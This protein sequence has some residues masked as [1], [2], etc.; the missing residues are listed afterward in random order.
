MGQIIGIDLGTTNSAVA[1]FDGD[2]PVLV[3][4]DRG[5]RITPSIVAFDEAGTILIGESAKNQAVVNAR[6][7]A[8]YVKR[9]LGDPQWRFEV[10]DRVYTA[11]ELSGLILK[12]LKSDAERY[13]GTTIESAV[14]TVPAHFG[15]A[16]RKATIEAGHIA[17]LRVPRILNEPTSAALA[18]AH[19][20]TGTNRI[21]V[22]DLGGGTFDVTCLLQ[23]GSE[24]TVRSTAGDSSLGGIDFDRLLLDAVAADFE[25]QSGLDLRGDP[26]MLQQLTELCERAK[27]EL[28]TQETATV[29]IPFIGAG[30]AMHLRRTIHR[31][32]LNELIAPLVRRTVKLTLQAV[33]EAG[34]GLEGIDALVLS[35]GSSRIP[36]VHS[37]LRRALGLGEVALVNPDEIVA[38]GAAVQAALL[39]NGAGATLRDVT[40]FNLGVEI[41]GG[42]FVPIVLRNAQLPTTEKRVFTTI[43]DDQHSVEIHVMQGDSDVVGENQSLGRFLLSGIRSAAKGKPRIEVSFMLDEDGLATITATDKD[44]QAHERIEVTP[45][46]HADALPEDAVERRRA[47]E[48]TALL[49]RIELLMRE[50]R[51]GVDGDLQEDIAKIVAYSRG[52]LAEARP[53]I[54][55]RNLIALRAAQG[56]LSFDM[57]E[58]GLG[59]T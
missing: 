18:Y 15:E 44:T 48:I 8:S 19:R 1:H 6:R 31:D 36:L 52:T 50:R 37:Y 40:A 17:G 10:D 9:H 56:E 2:E 22:Y 28:S 34:F 59:K 51:A 12:K 3:P 24:F 23:E 38:A 26:V 11:E 16:E 27:I 25:A 20:W 57:E 42:V 45:V 43:A 32:E 47:L 33:K 30:S 41:D 14:I 49:S 13:L 54:L 55:R 58:Q 35:G 39:V 21:L 5:N 4:N 46:A 7:T 29:A 53:E